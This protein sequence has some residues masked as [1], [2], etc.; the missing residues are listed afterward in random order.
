MY[1]GNCSAAPL[2]ECAGGFCTQG[3]RAL[4]RPG[5]EERDRRELPQSMRLIPGVGADRHA[6][7]SPVPE[8][9]R[10]HLESHEELTC[11]YRR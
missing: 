4:A 11:G 2:H 7:V 1:L 5:A 10:P 9:V 3:H 6:P 8:D